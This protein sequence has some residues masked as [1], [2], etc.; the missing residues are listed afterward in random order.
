MKMNHGYVQI[1][2][3]FLSWLLLTLDKMLSSNVWKHVYV[4]TIG[5]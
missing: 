1:G 2:F 3:S 5:Q 4:T